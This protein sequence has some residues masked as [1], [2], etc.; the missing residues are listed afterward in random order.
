M[1]DSCQRMVPLSAAP[2]GRHPDC[3]RAGQARQHS[4]RRKHV[5][6]SPAQLYTDP[7]IPE[8]IPGAQGKF[9]TQWLMVL[10]PEERKYNTGLTVLYSDLSRTEERFAF[11]AA[12]RRH[13]PIS[14]ASRCSPLTG[15]D[16]TPEDTRFGFDSDLAAV[17]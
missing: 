13:E 4:V 1:E 8:T 12:M 2:T 15:T 14:S 6:L 5:R 10:L 9:Y 3:V 11:I 17:R 16:I 7:G